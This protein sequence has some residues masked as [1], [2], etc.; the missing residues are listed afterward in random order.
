[1]SAELLADLARVKAIFQQRTILLAMGLHP[2]T[3]QPWLPPR[4]RRLEAGSAD[5]G[6]RRG[7]PDAG[8]GG[9]S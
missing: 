8:M 1:M 2:D 9:E 6:G 7:F 3:L 4:I 5:A